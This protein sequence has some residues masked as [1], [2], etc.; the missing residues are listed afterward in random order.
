MKTKKILLLGLVAASL[1]ASCKK[2]ND[3]NTAAGLGFKA[4][5]ESNNGDSRTYLDG[6]DVK[7]MEGDSIMVANASGEQQVFKLA[8]GASTM[9]GDF[10]DANVAETFYTPDYVALY[11]G[12]NAEGVANTIDADG[13]A[14]FTLPSTQAITATGTFANKAMPMVAHSSTQ[15]LPFKNVLGGLVIPLVGDGL[16]VSKVVLTSL[17][18]TDKLWGVYTADCNS[19]DPVPTYVSG[20]NH[21][22]TLSCDVT[23][24]PATANDFI[25]M[26]PPG[27]LSKGFKVEVYDGTDFLYEKTADWSATPNPSFI[28]RSVL[29]KVDHNLE[30]VPPTPV[31]LVVTTISPT[32]ISTNSAYGKGTVSGG[33]PS[34]CGLCWKLGTGRPENDVPEVTIDND[35]SIT[36]TAGE[37]FAITFTEGLVKDNV[38]WVR[39]WA[40]N[41]AGQVFYGDP[42]PFATRKDYANDYGGR[43]PYKFSVASGRQVYFSVGN[44]QWS[45][46]N[47][48]SAPT[49]HVTTDG[50]APGTW[51]FAEYQ[52]EYV[53]NDE[54]GNVFLNGEHPDPSLNGMKCSNMAK[55]TEG[56]NYNGWYDL[57]GFATS[58]Y[59]HSYNPIPST[60]PTRY[61]PWEYFQETPNRQTYLGYGPVRKVSNSRWE[62]YDLTGSFAKCDWGVF[63]DIINDGPE[64]EN[65][66]NKWRVMKGP[67]WQGT[68]GLNPGGCTQQD[69]ETNGC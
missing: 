20:G 36:A 25:F 32:F 9:N 15:T 33:T 7:W 24:N 8:G 44:L 17:E 35:Y 6:I 61:Q 10:Y 66:P 64:N 4:I 53:G 65:M 14:T 16:H 37:A 58:G 30:V 52:F 26:V 54:L 51:R 22:L 27:M 38:Y 39:A 23:L 2:N 63:N 34:Q 47:G 67:S 49:T 57:F 48:G 45:A 21:Q 59:K 13:I 60:H 43:L 69:G 3:N 55:Q 5:T 50:T 18:D 12:K 28:P 31:D 40:K 68:V 41:A 29:M 56:E 62:T 11:P 46:T 42:I 19:D 1:L